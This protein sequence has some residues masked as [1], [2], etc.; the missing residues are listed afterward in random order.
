M[1][2][3]IVSS[4]LQAT[5]GSKVDTYFDRVVKYIPADIVSAWV[6]VTGLINGR[7]DIPVTAILWIAF[8]V[9]ITTTALWIKRETAEPRKRAALTQILVSTGA[10]IVWVFAL[11]GPFST[12]AFYKPVYGSLLLIFYTLIVGLINP[13]DS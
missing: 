7:E 13:P 3:R 4:Q 11:G 1:S 5:T 12:L 8:F 9:G 10:F 2:R 6:A